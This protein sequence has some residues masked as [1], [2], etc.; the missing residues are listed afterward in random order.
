MTI[1]IGEIWDRDTERGGPDAS[2]SRRTWRVRTNNR[3][4]REEAIIGYGI[5]NGYFPNR[6]YPHPDNAYLTARTL[7]CKQQSDSPLHWI[8]EVEYS[9]E[10]A[11]ESEKEKEQQPNPLLRPTKY[12]WTTNRYARAVYTSKTPIKYVDTDGTLVDEPG[13]NAIVNSAGEYFDPPLEIDVSH[14]NIVGTKNVAAVPTWVLSVDNPVNSSTTPIMGV[15]FPAY[16]LKLQEM[17]ISEL[18]NEG[19]YQ[20]YVFTFQIEY[21]KET[22][23]LFAIDQGL[24]QKSGSDRVNIKDKDGKTVTAPWPL[25]GLG[26]KIADPT[27]SNI[28]RLQAEVYDLMDFNTLPLI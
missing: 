21:R 23:R 17:E 9:S 27:P 5:T 10:P 8:V 26:I 12:K 4:I 1:T 6:F 20:F 18:Q 11:K 22:W 13:G 25:D 7:R 16:T 19:D 14:W 15:S 24:R 28:K 3:F 2:R